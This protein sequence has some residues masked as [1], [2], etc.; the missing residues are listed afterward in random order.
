[1]ALIF[2]LLLT[3]AIP[4]EAGAQFA[5]GGFGGGQGGGFGGGGQ[6]GGFGGQGQGQGGGFGQGRV[7]G[8]AIDA[9]G[10][11]APVFQKQMSSKLAQKRLQSF[12]E[13][14]FPADLNAPSELRMISLVRLEQACRKFAEEKKHVTP[15]IQYL[16]GL[17]RID[18]VFL[19]PDTGDLV[20]AGP[21]EGFAP[22]EMGRVVGVST[23]RPPVRLD[24][25]IVALRTVPRTSQ[26]GCSIDPTPSGLQ[27][28]GDY[29]RRNSTPAT[30]AV[31]Q[32][33]FREMAK[34]LGQQDV[35]VF[36]VPGD[37]HFAQVLVEADYRMKLMAT[38]LEKPRL[39]RFVS[40]LQ[41]IR[42]GQN[43]FQR[44]WFTPLY[45]A[46]QQSEA[47]DAFA[48]SGQ[49]MQLMAEEER[50]SADGIRTSVKANGVSTQ[51]F[52]GQFTKRF[53]ELTKIVPVFAELQNITDLAVLAAL[54]QKKQLARKV[55]WEMSLFLDEARTPLVK[56]NVPKHVQSV[57][58]TRLAGR[59]ILGLVA[60][61]VELNPFQTVSNTKF[62]PASPELTEASTKAR[63]VATPENWWW[64]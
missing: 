44:W 37:S 31:I 47:G 32:Q 14:N 39:K 24:D 33:R 3:V 16:A 52:A 58:G 5:G 15:E 8:I 23:G 41:V 29:V 46:F 40:H 12:A 60:G 13:K 35:S 4:P 62:E 19:Y 21:A 64:D 48:F 63:R 57:Y 42:P 55:G 26:I 38:G 61:G 30:T 9:S 49:R 11:V 43:T 20:I 34:A 59:L 18:Y 7:G 22:D 17:Q 51:K 27:A 56:G 2:G 54:M 53:E 6:G 25:L 36:G 10:V 45:D 28:F 50:V 1:M